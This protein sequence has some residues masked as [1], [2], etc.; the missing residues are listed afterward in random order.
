[1]VLHWA[2]ATLQAAMLHVKR[3]GYSLPSQVPRLLHQFL[4]VLLLQNNS[5]RQSVG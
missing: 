1:M 5:V 2:V 4:E 3:S